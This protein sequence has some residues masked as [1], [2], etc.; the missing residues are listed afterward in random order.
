MQPVTDDREFGLGLFDCHTRLQPADAEHGVA[1]IG[2]FLGQGKRSD[3][4]H[5]TARREDCS[6]VERCR[7]HSDDGAGTIVQRDRSADDKRIS[8][9]AALPEAVAEEDGASFD[10]QAI[11]SKPLALLGRK[12][13]TVQGDNSK[14]WQEVFGHAHTAQALGVAPTRECQPEVVGE[15]EVGSE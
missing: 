6:K 2:G 15:R 7:E 10:A 9:K 12:V 4:I 3:D 13:A 5:I 14:G 8:A 1:I 11:S